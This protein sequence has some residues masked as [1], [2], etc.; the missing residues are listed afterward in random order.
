M[1]QIFNSVTQQKEPFKP[2]TPNKIGMYVCGITVYDHC[3]IGHARAVVAFDVIYRYLKSMGFDVNYVRNITDVDDKIINRAAERNE[4]IATMTEYFIREMYEDFDALS[5]LRP[6][7]EPRAT[8]NIHAIIDMITR[9]I[10]K[11]HAYQGR[12][13]DIYYAVDSFKDYG[14]L[15]HRKLEDMRAGERVEVNT[16][17]RNPLDFVL[18]KQAKP[19]EPSWASPWGAGRPGWHIECSAMA[20]QCL[21]DTF[22]IHGGGFDLQFPH[23]ENEIAQSEGATGKDF[24]HTWM[25]VG[26]VNIDDEKMSKSLN[27]FFTIR[28]VLADYDADVLRFFL[29]ASHYRSPINYSLDNLA[30]ARSSLMR[31]YTALRGCNTIIPA[32]D[33]NF[34]KAFHEAMQDDFNTPVALAVLFDIAREINRVKENDPARADQLASTLTQLGGILGILEKDPEVFLRGSEEDKAH[35]EQ[36]IHELIVQRNRARMSRDFAASDK[37]RDELLARGIILEDAAGVTTWRRR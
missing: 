15:S 17:K 12:T 5:V 27:N 20:T 18:W 6:T 19:H 7:L 22:D 8:E 35:E 25:H 2:L 11:G 31:L 13:G 3:H 10:D 30:K 4:D 37:I 28:E 33:E 16:D 32:M 26:F 9:L 36:E 21:G 23:H 29:L 34:A 1:L 24:A 14:K